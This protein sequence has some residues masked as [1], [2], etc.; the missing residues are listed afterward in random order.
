MD[1]T[2]TFETLTEEFI[3]EFCYDDTEDDRILELY[4]EKHGQSSRSMPRKSIFRDREAEPNL[5]EEPPVQYETY[6]HNTLQMRDKRTHRQ[7]QNDLVEHISQFHNN[8]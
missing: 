3:H 5:G 2:P 4:H 7:L 6:I 8:R 1:Q